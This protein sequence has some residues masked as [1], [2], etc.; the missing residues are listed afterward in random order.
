MRTTASSVSILVMNP[1]G[2]GLGEAEGVR[3]ALIAWSL[4]AVAPVLLLWLRRSPIREEMT[5]WVKARPPVSDGLA[6]LHGRVDPPLPT[7]AQLAVVVMS[8]PLARRAPSPESQFITKR[9]C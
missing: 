9:H 3:W 6:R 4:F 8:S 1:I 2:F 7:P 5:S